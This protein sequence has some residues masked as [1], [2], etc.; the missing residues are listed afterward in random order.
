MHS[1]LRDDGE[2]RFRTL[3]EALPQIVWTAIPGNGV[4]YCNRRWYELTGFTEAQTLGWGWPN[5]LHPDDRPV[6]L[7]NWEKCRHTG[8]SFEMEY[9]LLNAAGGFRWHPVR[10]TPM[11]DSGVIVKWFGG[12]A[13]IDGQIRNQQLLEEQI[14][15]HTAALMEANTP[16]QSEMRERALAQQ[17][18]NL[19]NER[20]VR[21]LTKRS[22]RATNLAK[23]AEL[24]Q[25]CTEVKDAFSVVA[26]MAPKVFPELRGALHLFNASRERLEVA[27]IWGIA[28]C[29]TTRL[30]RKTA[31]LSAPGTCTSS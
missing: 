10:A 5:A 23:M 8:K 30:D 12:C 1:V 15:Q 11:R 2:I 28:L 19:Q 21:E 20:M 13:D 16:L 22:N 4:D 31:G 29:R 25:S 27:A 6:A 24:L 3:A 26:G 14:R 18:L 17:E 9:R 7:G